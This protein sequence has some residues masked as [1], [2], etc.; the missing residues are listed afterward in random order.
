MLTCLLNHLAS[1]TNAIAPSIPPLSPPAKVSDKFFVKNSLVEIKRL[2]QEVVEKNAVIEERDAS[3]TIL[4]QDIKVKR[5]ASL[6]LNSTT[7]VAVCP[8][9]RIYLKRSIQSLPPLMPSYTLQ[10]PLTSR[11]TQLPP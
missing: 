11:L 8:V 6:K 9:S 7:E 5:F 1:S 3:I 4:G 10:M 2:K